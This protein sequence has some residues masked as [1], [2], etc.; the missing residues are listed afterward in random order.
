[1]IQG[2]D[3]LKV[4][5][6]FCCLCFASQPVVSG[7]VSLS[8]MFDVHSKMELEPFPFMEVS[9]GTRILLQ[10]IRAQASCQW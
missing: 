10:S 7:V 6:L 4:C 9:L 8:C 5:M 3:F 2:G 1:M